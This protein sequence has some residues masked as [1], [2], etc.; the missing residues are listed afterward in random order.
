MRRPAAGGVSIRVGPEP[1]RIVVVGVSAISAVGLICLYNVI[2][3]HDVPCILIPMG[4]GVAAAI[5]LLVH[6]T[7]R[8]Q[9]RAVWRVRRQRLRLAEHVN[10]RWERL[11]LRAGQV[12]DVR[13][14]NV[15]RSEVELQL[16]AVEGAVHRRR[17][18]IPVET[19]AIAFELRDALGLPPM[20]A[21]RQANLAAA[22]DVPQPLATAAPL[23]P[24]VLDYQTPAARQPTL[25]EPKLTR[26]MEVQRQ[27]GKLVI[28]IDREGAPPATIELTADRLTFRQDGWVRAFES[29]E[30]VGL[31]VD[32]RHDAVMVATVGRHG[33]RLEGVLWGGPFAYNT[34]LAA[35]W[36]VSDAMALPRT[37]VDPPR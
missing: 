4:I 18:G 28:T 17:A 26:H 7:P 2:R 20:R 27:P 24:P 30:V 1:L 15:T 16:K 35:A 8:S 29:D 13:F 23:A 37:G 25:E 33:Y 31:W 11:T 3:H 22:T 21:L 36:L 6:V 34:R 12:A 14:Q 32:K 10:G 19:V 9:Y 5:V